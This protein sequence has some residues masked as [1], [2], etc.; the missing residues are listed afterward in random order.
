M[1]APM[2]E[3]MNISEEE[4]RKRIE[5]AT[6]DLRR[7]LEQAAKTIRSLDLR[8]AIAEWAVAGVLSR[9]LRLNV[10]AG[11]QLQAEQN[12]VDLA[13]ALGANAG[14]QFL[15]AAEL[16]FKEHAEHSRLMA[17]VPPHTNYLH[18]SIDDEF[19]AS[20]AFWPRPFK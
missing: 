13:R 4:C 19:S 5:S 2:R 9:N 12:A 18:S 11:A 20:R 1:S 10:S 16:A 17:E 6:A 14:H 7:E 15:H 8:A 3:Q